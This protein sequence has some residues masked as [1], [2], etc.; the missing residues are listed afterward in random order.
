MIVQKILNNNLV[1]VADEEGREQIVMGKGL[2][3]FA[4]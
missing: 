1:L 4:R 2:R 3:F